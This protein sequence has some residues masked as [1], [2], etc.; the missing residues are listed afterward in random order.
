MDPQSLSV[1][2]AAARVGLTTHTLRWY[3]QVGLVDPV[4]R[5]TAGRRRYTDHDLARL[6]FLHRM[7][8]TGMPVRD[9]TRYIRLL[10]AGPETVP[11]RRAML[12]EHRDRV[13]AQIEELRGHLDAIDRKIDNYSE[14]MT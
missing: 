2:E 9:M 3:E 6:A 14:L 1:G 4:G 7:R 5:D 11:E 8:A 12:V 13:L 10:R